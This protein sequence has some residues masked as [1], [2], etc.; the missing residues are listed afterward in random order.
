MIPVELRNYGL[1]EKCELHSDTLH[2]FCPKCHYIRKVEI[3]LARLTV[4]WGQDSY[5]THLEYKSRDLIQ[6]GHAVINANGFNTY[7]K[8]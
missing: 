3:Y 5:Y 4:H 8:L 2:L 7:F 1:I 6:A